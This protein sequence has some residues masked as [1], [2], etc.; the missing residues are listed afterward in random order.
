MICLSFSN[1]SPQSSSYKREQDSRYFQS[2]CIH[3]FLCPFLLP[4]LH[5]HYLLNKR[6]TPAHNSPALLR[7]Q[8]GGIFSLGLGFF[9]PVLYI[10]SHFALF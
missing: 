10:A 8:K 2:L 1:T 5:L 6:M 4:V 7:Q 3:H 9:Y